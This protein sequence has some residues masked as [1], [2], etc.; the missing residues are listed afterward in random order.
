MAKKS[1]KKFTLRDLEKRIAVRAK[2]RAEKSYTR[3]LLGRGIAF[4]AKKLGEEA[5]ETT[6]AAIGQ[7]K[8]RVTEEAADLLYHL[9]VVLKARK[10]SLK[11]V[12][13]TLAKRTMQSGHAEKASRNKKRR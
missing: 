12:E 8:K 4:A 3:T 5:I 7:S 11:D 10:V 1:A 13:A 2:V 9:L 6:I